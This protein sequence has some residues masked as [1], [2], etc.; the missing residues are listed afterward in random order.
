MLTF[1]SDSTPGP[2][3]ADP[4]ARSR[5]RRRALLALLLLVPIPSIG[6]ASAMVIDATEGT[7]WG[8]AIFAAAKV[9]LIVFPAAWLLLVERGRPSLS[10]ARRGGFG[11]AAALGVLISVVIVAAWWLVGR[12]WIDPDLIR[13][14]AATT[15][16][17][18][19]WMYLA[20]AAWTCTINSVLEEYVWRWFV[21]RQCE[22]LLPGGRG[23][24]AVLLSAALFTVHHVFALR[25]QFGWDVTALAS[26]G[27]F[28]GGAVWSWCYLR[29]RSIWP[30]WLSHVIVDITVFAIGWILIFG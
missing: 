6:T 26:A 10:P 8:R 16:I 17:D 12:A 7:D 20:F 15:G 30:G 27:V 1:A 19:P 11:P 2:A 23:V 25:A 24:P 4:S 14:T 3:L 13:A 21:F 5:A 18:D 22:V 29:Y 9:L 28:I